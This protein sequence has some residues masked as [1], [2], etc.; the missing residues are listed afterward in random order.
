M[1]VL[2]AEEREEKNWE[3]SKENYED[4]QNII[5]NGNQLELYSDVERLLPENVNPECIQREMVIEPYVPITKDSR[6]SSPTRGKKVKRNNDIN[7]NIPLGALTGFVTAS[8]LRPK[9]SKAKNTPKVK[10]IDDFRSSDVEDDSV[11]EEI[12]NGLQIRPDL[13]KKKTKGKEKAPSKT[14]N[15]YLKKPIPDRL[16]DDNDDM[17][18]EGGIKPK[19]GKRKKTFASSSSSSPSLLPPGL[20]L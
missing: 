8:E 1:D 15:N 20:N 7:R 12:A 2:L 13:K 9:G 10:G 4:V 5:I 3:K 14:L 17:D 19:N 11:D 6:K 18:I 16:E